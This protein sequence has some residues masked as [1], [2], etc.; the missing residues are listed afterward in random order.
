MPPKPW[1]VLSSRRNRSYRI[2]EVRIDHARSPRT[3][4]SHDFYI[5]ESRDWVN[6][7]PLTSTGDVVLIRQYRH[8]IRENTLEIPGG[9]VEP[10]DSPEQAARRELAEETGYLERSMDYLG[11][12]HPNPAFLNNRCHTFVARDVRLNGEQDQD[13]KE[14]IEIVLYPLSDVPR[15]IR[16]NEITHALV[17][18]AF[19]RFTLDPAPAGHGGTK[20]PEPSRAREKPENPGDDP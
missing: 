8:G 18:A 6:V 10:G 20:S 14:D 15:L 9:I 7:I 3:G 1:D 16:E 17:L 11:Y 5:L 12:V 13:E 4:R 19:H 2:F